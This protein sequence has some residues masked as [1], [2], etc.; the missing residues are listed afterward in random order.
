[1]GDEELI[2][3]KEAELKDQSQKND[4]FNTNC[5]AYHHFAKCKSIFVKVP[6][7]GVWILLVTIVEVEILKE[8]KKFLASY[9]KVGYTYEVER[10]NSDEDDDE[11]HHDYPLHFLHYIIIKS[12][13]LLF[14]R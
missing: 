13:K 6:L 14:E 10:L 11:S 9:F 12:A 3:A 7:R 5:N 4:S 8:I 1:M 2:R